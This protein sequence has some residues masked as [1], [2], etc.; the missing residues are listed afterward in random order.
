MSEAESVQKESWRTL[1]PTKLRWGKFFYCP[2]FFQRVTLQ[3]CCGRAAIVARGYASVGG[4][5]HPE[6]ATQFQPCE[7][8][9]IRTLAIEKYHR[10]NQP[11]RHPR[12]EEGMEAKLLRMINKRRIRLF[13]E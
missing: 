6:L 1:N 7:F 3:M 10:S 11:A 5:K 13:G 9:S 4:D 12:L 2:V 8:C